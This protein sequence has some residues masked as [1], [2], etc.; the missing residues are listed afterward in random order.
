MSS[1]THTSGRLRLA[2]FLAILCAFPILLPAQ[3]W[4]V[5][6]NKG[7]STVRE[8]LSASCAS[9]HA[10]A[11]SYEG[12]ADPKRVTPRYPERSPLFTFLSD[13]SM[14][15]SG[16][17]LSPDQVALIS[18]WIATGAA[19]TD[20][21]IAG[22]APDT[23]AAATAASSTAAPVDGTASASPAAGP[24]PADSTAAATGEAGSTPT[25]GPKKLSPYAVKVRYHEISGFTSGG[26]LLASGIVGGVHLLNMMDFAH[27]Y[28]DA[29]GMEE[30][31]PECSVKIREAWNGDQTLRWVHVA[32]FSTGELLYLTDAITGLTMLTPDRPG[33]TKQD[34]HR[35]AFFTHAA[36][37]AAEIVMGFITTDALKR[38]DHNTMLAL[39]VAHTAVGLA[40]PAVILT[41]GVLASLR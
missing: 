21:P 40:I 7:F 36:L 24:A 25:A 13:G 31:S 28:R 22:A 8:I 18:A 23:T 41:A 10:W 35:Y 14:P 27:A 39:G 20:A 3:G 33:L 29:H 34:I 38:G 12:I 4:S 30:I 1:I 37:M 6:P 15:P 9:C 11:R 32:L 26:L 19:S 16:A 2:A 5:P 17:K